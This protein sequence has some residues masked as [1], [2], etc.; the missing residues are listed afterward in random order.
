MR[1]I[2]RHLLVEFIVATTGVFLGIAAMWFAADILLHIDDLA[3]HVLAGLREVALRALPVL[4]IVLPLSGLTGAVLCLSRAVRNRELT[5]IRTGGI[6][7]Q[8]ALAPL[9]ILCALVA[10]GL[11]VLEDRVLLPLRER[12]EAG[13]AADDEGTRAPERLLKRWWFASGA[14]IFSAASYDLETH[15]LHDVTVFL[16]DEKREIRQRID[17]KTATSVDGDT[18]EIR[19]AHVLD[20]SSD[21]GIARHE[22]P[23]L[24]LNL[25][26]TGTEMS[27][28]TDP[29]A[30]ASLHQLA[31]LIRK[32]GHDAAEK[33]KLELAFH[34]RLAQP[35]AVLIVVLLAIPF[36]TGD[37]GKADSLP[38]ALLRS[39]GAAAVFWLCWTV[40]LLAARGG[41][42]PAPLPVWGV[43]LGA[44]ALGF[45]RYRLIPE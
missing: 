44:L 38:R 7:L 40:A 25:G 42:V 1:T 17:A 2:A 41:Q 4:P 36:A 22:A 8:A 20:F 15:A 11:G 21:E 34:S 23:S 19:D 6:R 27:R 26:I 10:G 45:W 33:A 14:S 31:R 12:L 39:L 9:L 13:R 3:G 37:S 28:A 24:R 18:W 35:F 29:A 43:T 32:S 5:A 16:F 30:T